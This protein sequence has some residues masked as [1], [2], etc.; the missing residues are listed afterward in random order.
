MDDF[1]SQMNA[2]LGNPEMMQKIMALAND[3]QQGPAKPAEAPQEGPDVA[4]LQKLMGFAQQAKVDSNQQQ[5][6]QALGPYLNRTRIS[7]L[8]RAMQAAR[9][10]GM[11]TTL[12]PHLQIGR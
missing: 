5:L 1:Q 9:M 7:K 3:F 6:L 8:E 11:A 12:L 10:A 4:M 2:I